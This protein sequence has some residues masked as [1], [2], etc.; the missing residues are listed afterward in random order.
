MALLEILRFPDPRLREISKPIKKVSPDLKSLADDLVETMYASKGIGLAAP[1]VGNLVRLIAVDTRPRKDGRYEIE[2]MTEMEKTFSY[3][4]VLFNPRIIKA[5]GK[6]TFEEGCLSVPSFFEI[7][8]RASLVEVHGLDREGKEVKIVTDGLLAICLQHEMDHLDGKLFID[9]LSL[10]KS[11][12]IKNK[13]KKEG[14][15]EKTSRRRGNNS[16]DG[17][18][19]NED[20]I[21]L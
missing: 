13:I 6:T 2:E 7:V 16:D 5:E 10:I 14:Y 21:P 17:D 1:Q 11:T 8:Q 12:R 3:P 20:D 15:P 19:S 4:I 9:H 18:D